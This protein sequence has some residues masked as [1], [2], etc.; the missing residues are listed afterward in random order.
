MPL[1]QSDDPLRHRPAAS[2]TEDL[3]LAH[4]DLHRRLQRIS[5]P[6][7]DGFRLSLMGSR[8]LSSTNELSGG[9]MA[10]TLRIGAVVAIGGMT[11][12]GALLTGMRSGQADEPFELRASQGLLE[13]RIQQPAEG[14]QARA[15]PP[16]R[17]AG[18]GGRV[19]RPLLIPTPGTTLT[20]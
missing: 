20:R 2:A 16:P 11:A 19:P 9:P 18:I 1:Q 13:S 8:L 5:I 6:A 4:S 10:G 17:N 12:I 3:D 14:G 7:L 15:K